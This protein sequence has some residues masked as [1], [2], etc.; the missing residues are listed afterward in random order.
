MEGAVRVFAGEF[1]RSTLSVAGEEDGS[2]PSVVTPGGAY[3][4]LVLVA[5]ALTEI[6]ESGDFIR[7]RLADPT[8]GFD[9]IN[10][11][12]NPELSTLIRNLSLPSFVSVVGRA[13]LYRRNGTISLSIR[14]DQMTVIDRSVR[15]QLVLV[16]AASTLQRLEDLRQVLR[17]QSP[18][19]RIITA[20][21][22]YKVGDR[23]LEDMVMMVESAI[24]SVRPPGSAAKEQTDAKARVLDL[25]TASKSPRGIAVQEIVEI[26][27]KEG[28]SQGCVLSAIE[29]LIVE[30]ECYQPQKGFVRLL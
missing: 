10:G 5:G 29:T 14:P 26:I 3:C 6:S 1:G 21:R 16:T 24:Q 2:P 12:K 13:Q 22:H 25:I 17:G 20:M 27:I 8:G 28:I 9:L 11:G 7:G 30:D 4:R 18:D 19:E 23:D 15:D